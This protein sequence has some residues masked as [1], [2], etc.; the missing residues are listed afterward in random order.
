[1][2]APFHA[3]GMLDP[4]LSVVGYGSYREADGGWQMGAGLDVLRGLGSVPP[5][6]EF[7]VKWPSDGKTVSLT[8]HWGESPSPL[9]SCPGYSAP[10]GLPIILQIGSG[11]LVPTVTAHSFTQDGTPLDHCVFDETSYTNPNGSLQS[12]GRS[13]LNAR[14]AIVLIPRQPLTRGA[15]YTASITVN[16]Q[17]HTWTF[18]VSSTATA[19][20]RADSDSALRLDDAGL[21]V[22][23]HRSA[24][25]LGHRRP[26]N[27]ARA[28]RQA[29]P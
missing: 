6:V 23:S 5:A 14:D 16:G 11:G 15:S 22:E 7:P 8:A 13:I 2:Q 19:A 18:T 26:S 3:V 25:M 20:L 29:R 4:Q 1:M 9:T 17:T 10:S 27:L 21:M 24:S 28:R 12:V